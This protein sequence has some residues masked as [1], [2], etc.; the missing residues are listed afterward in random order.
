MSILGFNLQQEDIWTFEHMLM[1]T[2]YPTASIIK[3]PQASNNVRSSRTQCT[4]S[5]TSSAA[6]LI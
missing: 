4:S 6:A 5:P 3:Q 2:A 1:V